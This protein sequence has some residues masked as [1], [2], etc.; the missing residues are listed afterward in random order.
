[1]ASTV[2]K[3]MTPTVLLALIERMS[4]QELINNLGTLK[5]RGALDNPDLKS[6]IEEK[7]EAAKTGKRV[8][9]LKAEE[10]VKAT[11][12][13]GDLREKLEDVADTQIKAKGRIKRPTALL[14]DKS[15]SMHEAIELGKRIGAMISAVCEDKLYVYAFDTMAYEI[16]AQ[17]ADM[18]DWEK[19]F[20]G[21]T[22]GGA[23]SCGVPLS[24]MRKAKQYVEQ[25]VLITDEGEN[26]YPL[27]VNELVEYKRDLKSDPSICVVK[28]PGAS[29]HLERQFRERNLMFDVFQFAGDYYS[30]PNLVPLLSRPSK[31]ELLMEIMQFPLPERKPA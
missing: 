10:A 25:I 2:V 5:R 27:F 17:G 15:A 16:P 13:S 26:N 29:D 28:T 20:R 14:V 21:I 24:Y 1:V 9:A 22:A 8:S 19:A 7:L 30:L 11:G 3:Q 18:A 6:M 4:S 31:L 12:V 23:T